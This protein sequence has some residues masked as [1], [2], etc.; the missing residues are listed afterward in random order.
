MNNRDK[1]LKQKKDEHR[2]NKMIEAVADLFWEYD[3]MSSSGKETLDNLAIL[4]GIPTQE[5]FEKDIH[6]ACT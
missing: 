4:V 5:E 6:N 1:V 3:R 2:E